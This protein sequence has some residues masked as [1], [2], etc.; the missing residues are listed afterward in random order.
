M[1]ERD[2]FD[3]ER[4][5]MTEI[6]FFDGEGFFL[7]ERDFFSFLTESFGKL[8]NFVARHSF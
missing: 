2:F 3:G 4:I 1:T 8:F 5:L 7:T 6:D